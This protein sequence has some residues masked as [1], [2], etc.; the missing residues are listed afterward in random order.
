MAVYSDRLACDQGVYIMQNTMAAEKRQK[1]EKK[2]VHK[3]RGKKPPAATS[4]VRITS[5]ILVL[6]IR[7]MIIGPWIRIVTSLNNEF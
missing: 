4:V 7:V 5:Q 1:G 3:K 6:R 2:K